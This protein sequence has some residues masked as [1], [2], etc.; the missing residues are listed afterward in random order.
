MKEVGYFR[1]TG[2]L[3]KLILVIV[4]INSVHILRA[5][6]AP[7]F[8]TDIAV[9]SRGELVI[10]EKGMNRVRFFSSDGKHEL[11]TVALGEPPT[12]IALD[13]TYL[14]VTT[15]DK[16]GKLHIVA[17]NSGTVET[18][19]VTGFGA[20][21]PLLDSE[22]ARLYVCNQFQN[23][24]SEVDLNSRQVIRTANVLREPKSVLLSK[25]GKYLFLTNYLPAQQ[26]NL[27]EVAA[28][29]SVIRM[30]DFTKVKD[31]K[32][33]NGSNALRGMCL[34]TDGQYIYVSHNLGRFTVPTS[35]LQQGW[36]NT[37]AFSIINVASQEYWGAV[38]V[39]EPERGAAGI[40][41]IACNEKSL[42]IIHS[43]THE[44]SII[45]QKAMLDKFLAYP[46]KKMLDYDLRFLYGL[47][48]RIPLKGNGP[49]EMALADGKLFIPS[50]FAYFLNIVYIETGQVVAIEQNPMRQ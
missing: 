15:F 46:D 27:D 23:T 36:M 43:G 40:W 29:V 41:S 2:Y 9:S 34:S 8:Y 42:F 49:R 28:C 45:D 38:I 31:I 1:Q 21:A 20:C 3:L 24:I 7:F 35:Q 10:A 25:D 39:D 37:S 26:A 14:Y 19:I 6:T 13:D 11:R 16:I 12:G 18:T 48:K 17:L 22:R 30:D 5:G 44:V 47:R 33:A 4:C 50:Y 32:L